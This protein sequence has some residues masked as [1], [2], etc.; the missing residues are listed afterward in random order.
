ME[1]IEEIHRLYNQ[2]EKSLREIVDITGYAFETVQKYAY[3]KNFKIY[4]KRQLI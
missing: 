4:V 2:E 3:M 1:K